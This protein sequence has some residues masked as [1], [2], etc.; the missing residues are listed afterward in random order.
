MT[1][2]YLPSEGSVS[3]D[4]LDYQIANGL[5]HDFVITGI[6][7]ML[8]LTN[9]G[10]V[11]AHCKNHYDV[12]QPP[13]SINIK[14]DSV[15]FTTLIQLQL[16]Q[17][18]LDNTMIT[19]INEVAITEVD[20]CNWGTSV[21]IEHHL[22]KTDGNYFISASKHGTVYIEDFYDHGE[23]VNVK[24]LL[25]GG[26]KTARKKPNRVCLILTSVDSVLNSELL[27]HYI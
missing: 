14:K 6:E 25:V 9:N 22:H 18:G 12:N 23:K 16:D 19:K 27:K 21:V 3:K 20:L 2:I 8:V 17:C 10:K 4:K 13:N 24:K 5:L 15:I 7:S 1:S 11:L 26:R